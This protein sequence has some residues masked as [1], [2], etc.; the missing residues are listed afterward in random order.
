MIFHNEDGASNAGQLIQRDEVRMTQIGV[1]AAGNPVFGH[2]HQPETPTVDIVDHVV[3]LE[4][5]G[6]GIN[7]GASYDPLGVKAL[8]TTRYFGIEMQ[9]IE[10]IELRLADGRPAVTTGPIS[11][12][13]PAD[14]GADNFTVVNT[15][16]DMHLTIWG[17]GGNDVITVRGIGGPTKIAGGAGDDVVTVGLGLDGI[18]NNGNGQIDEASELTTAGILSM[19]TVD[20]FAS[21][22]QTADPVLDNDPVVGTGPTSFLVVPLVVVP[23]GT[24]FHSSAGDWQKASFLPILVDHSPGINGSALNARTV[25]LDESGAIKIALVQEKGRVEYA[26]QKLQ[27]TS[28]LWFDAAGQETTDAT[29]TGIPVL[30]PSTQ[31]AGGSVVYVDAAQNKVLVARGA[32]LLV[33]GTMNSPVPSNGFGNGWTSSNIDS[34]GGWVNNYAGF[35]LNSNGGSTNPTISQT[36]TGLVPGLTYEISGWAYQRDHYGSAQSSTSFAASVNGVV[37]ATL[38]SSAFYWQHIDFQVTVNAATLT[39]TLEGERGDDTSWYTNFWSVQTVNPQ[40]WVT[41]WTSSTDIWIDSVGRKTSTDTGR[42]SLLPVNVTA[43]Q[44]FVRT[45]DHVTNAAPGNDT[46][47]IYDSGATGATHGDVRHLQ[48]QRRPARRRR[49]ADPARRREPD[50]VLDAGQPR[51]GVLH[52]RRA[53]PRSVHR[54]LAHLQRRATRSSTST[55]PARRSSSRIRSATRCITRQATSSC[56]GPATP[57]T[58]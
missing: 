49:P 27:G 37:Q 26:T 51:P 23:T 2:D 55:S 12:Q 17:G 39:L 6:L 52:R 54:R 19:L 25:V 20:G 9:G 36:I 3:S 1:D 11:G 24:V 8:D 31:A 50:D 56:T 47:N 13:H 35:A 46:L 21:L 28:P 22:D 57:C 42:P 10:N 5:A 38:P 18:D 58:T 30:L 32:E 33:N 44:P 7:A 29:L 4:G 34:A 53:R 15:P 40:S 43:E 16:A 45:S 48:A 41:D 14:D